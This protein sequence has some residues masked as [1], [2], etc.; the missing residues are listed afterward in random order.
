MEELKRSDIFS[1]KFIAQIEEQ[2]REVIL[3]A[4]A[5]EEDVK[6]ALSNY[7]S[8]LVFTVQRRIA[9]VMSTCLE[10]TKEKLVA[11]LE[12]GSK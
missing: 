9:E 8:H 2:Q 5:R 4:S 7:H 12:G 11:D 10:H 1:A 6:T 3:K